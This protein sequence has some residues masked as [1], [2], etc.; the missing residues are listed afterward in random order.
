MRSPPLL[1][2]ILSGLQ[3][4]FRLLQYMFIKKAPPYKDLRSRVPSNL[5]S[6]VERQEHFQGWLQVRGG[7]GAGGQIPEQGPALEHPRGK[8]PGSFFF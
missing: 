4:M 6:Q 8:L 3:E 2:C 5:T 1:V 7:G